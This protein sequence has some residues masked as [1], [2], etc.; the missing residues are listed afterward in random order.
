MAESGLHLP[1]TE[2][3]AGESCHPFIAVAYFEDE[4]QFRRAAPSERKQPASGRPAS[5]A[6]ALQRGRSAARTQ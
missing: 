2:C 3:Q 5:L 6:I 1:L 4:H